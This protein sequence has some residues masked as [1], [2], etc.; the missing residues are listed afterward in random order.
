MLFEGIEVDHSKLYTRQEVLDTL[1]K[2][3]ATY[4]AFSKISEHYE[5]EFGNN[6]IW[7][8]PITVGEA[9]GTVIIPVQEG[10]LSIAY[11]SIRSDIYEIYD[12]RNEHLLSSHDIELMREA[13][14][15]YSK[16]LMNALLDMQNI[17]SKKG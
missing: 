3:G 13:W 17:I 9:I 4:S 15:E 16:G 11:D 2:S 10:F 12:L 7:R 5:A 8:Y 1:S 6:L 14:M